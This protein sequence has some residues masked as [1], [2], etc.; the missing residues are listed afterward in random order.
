MVEYEVRALTKDYIFKQ[1]EG[2]IDEYV[3]TYKE[4]IGYLLYYPLIAIEYRFHEVDPNHQ[5]AIIDRFALS[6]FIGELFKRGINWELRF[7]YNEK[8]LKHFLAAYLGKI[9]DLYRD[10]NICDQIMDMNSIAKSECKEIE[11]N[12]YLFTTAIIEG[13]FRKEYIYFHGLDNQ[14]FGM[15]REIKMRLP[16]KIVEK[17][18][19]FGPRVYQKI[20]RLLVDRDRE[21]LELCYECVKVDLDY[22]GGNVKSTV[23]KNIRELNSI[24]SF[25]YYYSIVVRAAYTMGSNFNKTTSLDL[26]FFKDK[27]WFLS[28]AVQFTGLSIGKVE[29]YFNYFLFDGRG[30][31][32]EF[33]FILHNEKLIFVP[34][35]WMLNDLQFCVV[36]GHFYKGERFRNRDK[37]ISH[38]VVNS[39]TRRVET[40]K[41][42]VFGQEVYYEFQGDM[43]KINSD[44]DVAL[45]DKLSNTFII[46]ESKW[47][48]NHYTTAGEENYKKIHQSLNEIY[49]EQIS[50]HKD[51][52]KNDKEKLS[53]ILEGKVSPDEISDDLDILYIAVDKRSQLFIEDRLLVPLN[54]ML[55]LINVN[56]QD[57]VLNL[58]KIVKSLREQKSRG[59]Y[60]NTEDDFS[61]FKVSEDITIVTQDLYSI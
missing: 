24:I 20:K 36:N 50:K 21:L 1:I 41:N 47:K 57:G 39:I 17:F 43:G 27:E 38:S 61:E 40:F 34:S 3:T 23:V 37:T 44:I 31:L 5:Q 25:F 54:G 42:I 53:Y 29:K 10:F 35:S 59:L 9:K 58:D 6:W 13:G 28:K 32:L 26:L 7:E 18:S 30:S 19:H 45:Y 14:N 2:Y 12:K 49:N 11:K 22:L 60:I 55:A 4:N 51:F 16:Q 15:E 48:E 46:I 52:I 8:E 33:P 56:S